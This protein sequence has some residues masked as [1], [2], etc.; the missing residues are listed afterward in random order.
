MNDID[1]IK[2]LYKTTQY[3]LDQKCEFTPADRFHSVLVANGIMGLMVAKRAG[4]ID[5][6]V[7]PVVEWI[8]DKV[9][10]AKNQ[11]ESMDVSAESTLTSYI[12][13]NWNNVL[14]IASTQD[15]RKLEK[16]EVEHLVIP[17]ATP[18]IH[19][20]ARH[21]Y[22]INMLYLYIDPFKDWC[23]KKQVNYAGLVD[24]LKR[25]RTKAKINKKRMGKGTRMSLPALDV[26]WVNCE[27]FM[28]E[29]RQEELASIATHKAAIEGDA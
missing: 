24:S 2:E 3:R 29:D 17:D 16:D 4:L 10:N 14:R 19:F 7:K 13:E 21:E 11:V 23:V 6:D 18:R 20:I 1:G 26:L 15:S 9:K 27:G 5:Y 22:D 8:V 12:A 25:G 28:D